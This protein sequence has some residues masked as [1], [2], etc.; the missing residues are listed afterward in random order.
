MWR[1]FGRDRVM[2]VL[3]RCVRANSTGH[4]QYDLCDS[5]DKCALVLTN[6][7]FMHKAARIK[8]GFKHNAWHKSLADKL[9][10]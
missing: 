1:R 6:L 10:A 3:A 4:W 7:A 5:G 2:A 9:R 8:Y